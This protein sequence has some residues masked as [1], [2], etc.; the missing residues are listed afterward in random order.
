MN[1]SAVRLLIRRY[2]N[3]AHYITIKV[4]LLNM[5]N[6]GTDIEYHFKAEWLESDNVKK[7]CNLTLPNLKCHV[8]KMD[9]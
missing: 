8:Q 2:F 5:I 9:G 3:I 7:Q 6:N 1:H 4:T